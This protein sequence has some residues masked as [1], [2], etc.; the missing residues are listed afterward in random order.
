[1]ILKEKR[2]K[3]GQFFNYEEWIFDQR[4]ESRRDVL[5]VFNMLKCNG[6]EPKKYQLELDHDHTDFLPDC[7][8]DFGDL[9]SLQSDLHN[10][11]DWGK[12]VTVYYDRLEGS[13]YAKIY[14]GTDNAI[15]C[16]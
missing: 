4:I 5:E 6:Y 16:G 3:E 11:K 1:M 2:V 8:F 10:W 12:V 14:L 7:I 13:G 9:N 15:V